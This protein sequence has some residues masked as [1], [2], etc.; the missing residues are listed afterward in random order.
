MFRIQSH[1]MI[2]DLGFLYDRTCFEVTLYNCFSLV[3]DKNEHENYD[4]WFFKQTIK[5]KYDV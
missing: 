5:E 1:G 4:W 2:V 3:S